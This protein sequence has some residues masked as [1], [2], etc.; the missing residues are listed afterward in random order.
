MTAALRRTRDAPWFAAALAC[1]M[2]WVVVFWLAP[3]V[4]YDIVTANVAIAS[5][6]ALV[7]IGQMFPIASGGGGIDLSIPFVINFASFNAV[8]MVGSSTF[9][10]VEAFAVALGFGAL[11]GMVNG[12]V[13]VALRIPPIIGTLAV[14]FIVLTIVQLQSSAA[15]SSTLADPALTDFTR[16]TFLGVPNIFYVVLACAL[17]AGFLL[18]RTRYGRG[19][20]AVGQSPAAA[21]LAG[22]GVKRTIFFAYVI[23]GLFAAFAGTLLTGSVGSADLELGNPYLLASVGAVVLGGNL[24]SGGM[25]TVAG[26]VLGALLLTLL[27]SAVTLTG[28]DLGFQNV[29]RG[30][31]IVLVLLAARTDR[32]ERG[33]GRWLRSLWPAPHHD[34]SH[35]GR[36]L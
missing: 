5:Y 28:I 30:A 25:A 18:H 27:V 23:S 21:N 19:L 6:L 3:V 12:F 26:T 16:G 32:S 8:A 15:D 34:R 14:G 4:R 29:A 2:L 7:G 36:S 17:L 20:L 33:F 10:I 9:S 35:E 24:V 22:V 11:V 13:V 31:V 1:G